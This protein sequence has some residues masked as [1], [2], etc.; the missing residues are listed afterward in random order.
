MDDKYTKGLV[1]LPSGPRPLCP[2]HLVTFPSTS[3]QDC[4]LFVLQLESS[5]AALCL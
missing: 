3:Y 2:N 4:F 1:L 5:W